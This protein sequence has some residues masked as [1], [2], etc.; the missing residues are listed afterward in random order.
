MKAAVHVR[1][2]PPD[3]VQIRELPKPTAQP[4]EILVRVPAATVAAGD[5]RMRRPSVAA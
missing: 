2:G 4:T 3:I 5:W 1:Y